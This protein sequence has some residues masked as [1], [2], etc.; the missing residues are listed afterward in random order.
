MPPRLPLPQSE[1]FGTISMVAR[2]DGARVG[3][4]G[5]PLRVVYTDL[6][7]PIGSYWTALALPLLAAE[8]TP[9]SLASPPMESLV[10]AMI[11]VR[12]FSSRSALVLPV[13]SCLM[14]ISQ[15]S[16]CAACSLRLITFQTTAAATTAT[17]V[18]ASVAVVVPVI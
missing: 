5:V 9:S 16:S 3:V 14:S 12:R 4:L 8:A 2:A 15:R 10:G 13:R 18:Q 6:T 7:N 11:L 1:T 17:S